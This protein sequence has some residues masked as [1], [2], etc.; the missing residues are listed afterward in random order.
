MPAR[1]PEDLDRLIADALNAGNLDAAVALYEPNANMVTGP[2]KSV[3]GTKAI[4]EALSGMLAMKP[5]I[6]LTVR[7]AYVMGDLALIHADYTL[8]GTGPDGKPIN[9][10]GHSAEVA[11]RQRD[12]TWLFIIDNPNALE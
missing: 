8:T 11:R 1:K 4:R 2:G 9:M 6:N 5:K 12:G 10:E 7:R 3:T